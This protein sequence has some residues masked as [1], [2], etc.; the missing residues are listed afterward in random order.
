MAITHELVAADWTVDSATGDIRYTGHDHNGVSP[1]YATVI[2]FHRW[3]QGLADDQSP[4]DTSDEVYIAMLNPSQR[5]T[6]NIITLI[7]GYNIDDGAAEH[8]YD[9]SIIQDGGDTIYDGIVNFGN[10]NVQ[11]QIIQDGDVIDDDF[12][13]YNVGSAAT[14][15]SSATALE[16]SGET[17]TTDEWEGYT[18]KNTSATAR[19]GSIGRVDSNDAD[20]L[21]FTA[22][23]MHNGSSADGWA[24]TDT[25]LIGQ[26]LNPNATQ[27][28]SHR[29]MVKVRSDGADIDGRRLVGICRR[30]GNTYSE[31]KINGTSRG[32]NVLALADS[33][34][35]NCTTANTTV[36]G[37][38]WDGEFSGEDLGFE[39]FDVNGDGTNEEYY[40]K[41][42]WSG[43]HDI[44]DL[45]EY[46]KGQTEDGSG[47]TVHGLNGEV[48]RGI[49]YSFGYDAESG[50]IS[51]SDYDMVVWGTIIDHGTV[52]G[53]P[54]TVGEVIEDDAS[55]PAW[56]ARVLAVDAA[57]TNLIVDVT[58][59]TVGTES[60]TGVT[61]SAQATS[62]G[63]PTVV[64]GG[65][66]LH[67]IAND[68]TDDIF[69]VQVLKGT[70]ASDDDVLYYAGT[71]L[72][73]A[74]T[75]DTC[76]VNEAG[77]AI[78][79]RTI[80]TPIIGVSTGTAIIGSYGFGID[81]DKLLATD[82]VFDLT[83]T[84]ITPPNTVTNSVTGLEVG[85]DY[86][87]VAPWDG[88]SVDANGDP[89]V[90]TDQM[91]TNATYNAAS[92]YTISVVDIPDSTPN[93]GTIRIV[94]DEGFH[95]QCFYS[96]YSD[97]TND[98]TLRPADN[99]K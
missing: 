48:L 52:T 96:S 56:T 71:D 1:S 97:S 80:S 40:G 94:N 78:T 90:D 57:N 74:D 68:T 16:D 59:G 19:L 50:G 31:F 63:A 60:F 9:G 44:N 98:F 81:N 37:A 17:W 54:F 72:S 36:I 66:V 21:T 53:G 67:V 62:G 10:A 15:G 69:Y 91:S 4:A 24:D 70:M 47:Y 33:A 30:M 77:A 92:Q 38:T 76:Q 64:T 49:N 61:S 39:A 12:W 34:D 88:S 42:T 83:N 6:D 5:S 86:V 84:Q 43:S 82:K 29:F 45:Y 46:V 13:N 58:Y 26:P 95:V 14:A 51:V 87:F 7:N 79:E 85:Q 18:V 32:N 3:L 25:Y 99:F 35:L 75:T 22:G 73:T 2:E 20:T 55:S 28:I 65:G 27:G 93:S 41:Y 89:A 8:L 11:I 23:E